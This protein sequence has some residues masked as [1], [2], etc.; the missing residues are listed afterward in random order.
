MTDTHLFIYLLSSKTRFFIRLLLGWGGSGGV[1]EG[2][3]NALCPP[4]A[5]VETAVRTAPRPP[6][7]V[8]RQ[9]RFSTTRENRARAGAAEAPGA[10]GQGRRGR[11]GRRR[12]ELPTRRPDAQQS[13]A[14]GEA[15][16]AAAPSPRPARAAP[17][18]G[19][20]VRGQVDALR[21]PGGRGC[22]T[23]RPPAGP[24]QGPPNR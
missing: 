18:G 21:R 15:G 16:D 20:A 7:A 4:R 11:R 17:D 3:E 13:W 14:A 5:A 12:P 2:C 19:A 23:A 10:C 22:G 9:Q 8:A 1:G 6:A 24:A